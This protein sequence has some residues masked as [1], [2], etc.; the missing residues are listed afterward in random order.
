MSI[1]KEYLTPKELADLFKV[2]LSTIYRMVKNKEIPHLRFGKQ[3]RFDPEQV[4]GSCNSESS[5]SFLK[6]NGK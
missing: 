5:E 6:R 4:I 3:L 1:K 2:G